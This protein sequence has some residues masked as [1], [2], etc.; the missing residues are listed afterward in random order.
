[1]FNPSGCHM[2]HWR[3]EYLFINNCFFHISNYDFCIWGHGSTVCCCFYY[4]NYVNFMPDP[5][6]C[7]FLFLFILNPG[8]SIDCL[9]NSRP[10]GSSRQSPEIL[11]QEERPGW[12]LW[13]IIYICNISGFCN[14]LRHLMNLCNL[15][16]EDICNDS[17][18]S[19]SWFI[20]EI[21]PTFNFLCISKCI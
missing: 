13:E 8:N 21:K 14:L 5:L 7:L 2:E 16:N 6:S 1:M 9:K 4:T 18:N 20:L 3:A 11:S 10:R 17:R 19:E 15:N 12:P